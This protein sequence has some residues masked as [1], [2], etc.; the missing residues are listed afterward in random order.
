M[1]SR[2]VTKLVEDKP[3][4]LLIGLVNPVTQ[5]L[6]NLL[7]QQNLEV[8]TISPETVGSEIENGYHFEGVYKIFWLLQPQPHLD[9]SQE[10]MTWLATTDSKIVVLTAFSSPITDER[11]M[12]K[13]WSDQ[14]KYEQS[15]V[16]LLQTQLPTATLLIG[17]DVFFSVSTYTPLKSLLFFLAE[18]SLV[19]PSIVFTLQTA[20]SFCQAVLPN[21]MS[22]LPHRVV[23]QG[24]KIISTQLVKKIQLEYQRTRNVLPGIELLTT[25]AVKTSG[26][27]TVANPEPEPLISFVKDIPRIYSV[28]KIKKVSHR[29]ALD[30]ALP[31]PLPTDNSAMSRQG[32]PSLTFSETNTSLE[33]ETLSKSRNSPEL[34]ATSEPTESLLPEPP[35]IQ[36]QAQIEDQVVQLFDKYRSDHKVKRVEKLANTTVTT[37]RKQTRNKKL[38]WA[39]LVFVGSGLGVAVL[40]LIFWLSQWGLQSAVLATVENQN[41]PVLKKPV[42]ARALPTLSRLVEGQA[43]GYGLIL[44]NSFFS[45]AHQL[46]LLSQSLIK[47]ESDSQELSPLISSGVVMLLHNSG[48]AVSTLDQALTQTKVVYD[49]V[50]ELQAALKNSDLSRLSSTEQEALTEFEAQL[51]KQKKALLP[52]QYLQPLLP[53]LL[54]EDS[55][56]TYAIVLQNNQELRPTGGFIQAVGLV[57]V[58][59]GTIVGK[60]VMSV[61]DWDKQQLGQVT[62]PG[63]IIRFLGEK[64]WF[65]RDSNWNPDF[66]TTSRQ[67][68]WFLEKNS[69]G[70]KIDGVLA[71]NL[72]A[73]KDVLQTLGPVELPEYNEVITDKN[74]AERMEFHSEIQLVPG[75]TQDYS[76]LL[77]SRTLDKIVQSPPDKIPGLLAALGSNLESSQAQFSLTNPDENSSLTVLGWTGALL[78]P[79]CPNQLADVSCFVDVMA[80]VEANVGVNK[81]N[82]YITRKIQHSVAI[83]RQ[84]FRHTRRITYTNT[85]SSAAW[86]KG[87]Y[88]NYLRLYVSPGSQLESITINKIPVTN[89][90]IIIRDELDRRLFGVLVEVPIGQTVTVE[91][92]YA[93]P[94]SHQGPFA[95]AFFDQRQS[96]IEDPQLQVSFEDDPDLKPVVIAPQ[97]EVKN[98]RIIFTPS[99]LSHTFVGAQFN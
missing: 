79:A 13:D 22:P 32:L 83:S 54:A 44:D 77:L 99:P 45:R 68:A 41:T 1:S 66:P 18:H 73:L 67:I 97:A 42:F 95:Y 88:K 5:W 81:A 58:A 61:Y 34:V 93:V 78:H 69:Q 80:Q 4:V 24:K 50:S 3:K 51:A 76:T 16:N 28:S 87:T 23:I 35:V 10:I 2:I 86:P 55:R 89:D 17:Q 9:H 57:T 49:R 60:Q 74:L 63:E 31:S 40:S 70:Q 43:L 33:P 75:S 29:A 90:Q 53:T 46:V 91:T 52:G 64:Q 12:F 94:H 47:L 92:V 27:P 96:G 65:L 11:P 20:R 8:Q 84:Q 36:P 15:L 7:E 21:M 26:L 56:R 82:R 72:L 37:V 30:E 25:E 71:I 38:F 6:E 62:P 48:S 19:D 85:A 59:D 39:G 98:Q 14:S